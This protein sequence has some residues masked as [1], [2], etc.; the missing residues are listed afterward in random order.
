MEKLKIIWA[1]F[2]LLLGLV[3]FG[4]I[5]RV[6]LPFGEPP[7]E[8]LAKIWLPEGY[9]QGAG[10]GRDALA[11]F[12]LEWE[13]RGGA[14]K[15]EFSAYQAMDFVATYVH[16]EIVGEKVILCFLGR[17]Q[18]GHIFYAPTEWQPLLGPK[19]RLRFAYVDHTSD[20][21]NIVVETDGNWLGF[22]LFVIGMF[23]A[24]T[25][26]MGVGLYFAGEEA[27]KRNFG[28][29]EPPPEV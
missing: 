10:P 4:V 22:P 29:K 2:L 23:S 17:T 26:L 20:G 25:A 12:W 18:K 28:P 9:W 14:Y 19:W 24:I 21:S 1:C 13:E 16:P 27:I 3:I 11:R 7:T 5:S 15:V 6:F 8:S